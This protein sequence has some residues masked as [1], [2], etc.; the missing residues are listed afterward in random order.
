MKIFGRGDLGPVGRFSIALGAILLVTAL[1]V[2]GVSSLLLD[3]YVQDETARFTT[4]AVASHLG[5]VFK[6]DVFKRPLADD[7]RELLE[8]IVA[9]HFSIYNVVS[10]QSSIRPARSSSL[11]TTARSAAGWIPH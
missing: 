11:M 10:T 4:D 8:T 2:A 6:E 9:F 5:P 3:R 7:E 1:V